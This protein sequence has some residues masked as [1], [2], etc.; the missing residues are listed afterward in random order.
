[1]LDFENSNN[2]YEDRKKSVAQWKDASHEYCPSSNEI[3][4]LGREI[5][6]LGIKDCDSLH[7][8]FA[9]TCKSD[10]F[11]TTD[12]KLLN[13]NSR[14]FSNHTRFSVDF[15]RFMCLWLELLFLVMHLT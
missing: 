14:F 9:I 11:I 5:M 12:R 7:I 10:F 3:L 6:K 2:P 8:A 15:A 1:M 4:S 13:R